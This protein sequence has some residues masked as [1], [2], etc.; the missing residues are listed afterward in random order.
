M[1]WCPVISGPSIKGGNVVIGALFAVGTLIL[2]MIGM[3]ETRPFL[4]SI[5]VAFLIALCL[6]YWHNRHELNQ[7]RLGYKDRTNLN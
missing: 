4:C 5:P 2:L 7:I 1:D 3:R 6:R